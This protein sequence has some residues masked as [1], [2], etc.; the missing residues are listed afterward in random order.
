MHGAA[1]SGARADSHSSGGAG[2]KPAI[3]GGRFPASSGHDASGT[4]RRR[5][6]GGDGAESGSPAPD[7]QLVDTLRAWRLA[8]AK[9]K[10]VPAFRIFTDKTLYGLAAARPRDEE[11]LL[12][13]PGIGP[14]LAEKY[15]AVLLSFMR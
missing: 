9:K 8:E 10:R 7:S 5:R 12:E 6:P 2:S 11:G 14:R 1:H 13:V 4:V 3:G 15:G